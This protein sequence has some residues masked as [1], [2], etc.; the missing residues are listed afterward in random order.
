VG[1]IAWWKMGGGK[2]VVEN[3]W[4]KM[5]GGKWVVEN[6]IFWI[7]C[8]KCVLVFIMYFI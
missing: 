2:W 4:W 8:V 6:G 5:G 1:G 3:G 7:I